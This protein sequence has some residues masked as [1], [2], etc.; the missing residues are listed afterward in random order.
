MFRRSPA[1][2]HRGPYLT[3]AQ[4][5]KAAWNQFRIRAL[6]AWDRVDI[7]FESLRLH[8]LTEL[9]FTY[10]CELYKFTRDWERSM[11][12]NAPYLEGSAYDIS[13]TD[14]GYA[15][16]C[17]WT[18]RIWSRVDE[19]VEDDALFARPSTEAVDELLI[20]TF[21]H[22]LLYKRSLHM[23]FPQAGSQGP[24]LFP[25]FGQGEDDA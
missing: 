9:A 1:S 2:G 7:D 10:V 3:E 13:D 14:I 11:S 20:D 15:I 21:D 16:R 23:N 24:D 22:F 17:V 12:A 5:R 19:M 25:A 8:N 6:V 4:E 18:R